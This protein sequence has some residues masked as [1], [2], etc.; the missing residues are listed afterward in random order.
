MK[1]LIITGM[2]GAG[3]SIA[4]KSL[5]DIGYYCIDNMPPELMAPF[6]ELLKKSSDSFDKVALVMDTRSGSFFES[7]EENIRKLDNIQNEIGILF[8]DANNETLIR[9]FKETRRNHPL[10]KGKTIIDGIE[11]ERKIL[12]NIKTNSKY[13]IDS[14]NKSVNEL[15]EQIRDIFE[16]KEKAMFEIV[17]ESFGFKRGIPT[18]SDFVFDLRYLPNPFYI[19]E[20][21]EKTGNDKEVFDYVFS[22]ENSEKIFNKLLDLLLEMLEQYKKEGR[23]SCVLSIGCTGGKHR[24]VSFVNK[25]EREFSKRSYHVTKVHRDIMK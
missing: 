20:L 7:I 18:D 5:E 13:Y 16:S 24:S 15:K 4:I 14:T 21:R 19:E 2:S 6:I 1:I 25:L 12:E 22:F 3:K 10:S 8:L 17:L 11:Q 9:R 23:N